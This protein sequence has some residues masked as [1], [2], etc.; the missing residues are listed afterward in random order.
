MEK[1]ALVQLL[2]RRHDELRDQDFRFEGI[3]VGYGALPFGLA[4]DPPFQI[5]YLIGGNLK[6]SVESFETKSGDVLDGLRGN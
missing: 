4:I 3:D 2:R 6:S 5:P 1:I